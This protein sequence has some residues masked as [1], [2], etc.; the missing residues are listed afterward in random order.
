VELDHAAT[1]LAPSNN[2]RRRN[3]AMLAAVLIMPDVVLLAGT[4]VAFF[5]MLMAW[6]GK[7]R[8]SA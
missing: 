5:A 1:F 3:F 7:R 4:L 6:K 8:R 2:Y